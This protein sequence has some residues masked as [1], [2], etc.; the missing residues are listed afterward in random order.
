MSLTL[1]RGSAAAADLEADLEGMD[2]EGMDLEADLDANDEDEANEEAALRA[3]RSNSS[4]TE[5]SKGGHI[6]VIRSRREGL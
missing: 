6:Q 4:R 5:V 2:L 3:L 1:T